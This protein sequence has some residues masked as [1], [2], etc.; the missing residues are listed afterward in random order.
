MNDLA[1]SHNLQDRVLLFLMENSRERNRSF[2]VI[3]EMGLTKHHFTGA[4]RKTY[5]ILL[6][7]QNE[8]KMSHL[9]DL[10]AIYPESE[11][12]NAL[13][14]FKGGDKIAEATVFPELVEKVI[15]TAKQRDLRD[16]SWFIKSELAEGVPVDSIQSKVQKKL[17]DQIISA[18]PGS[19]NTKD[20][21]KSVQEYTLKTR[22]NKTL[23]YKTGLPLVTEITS[24]IQ[25]GSYWVVGGQ[26]SIG[27]TQLCQQ[28]MLGAASDGAKVMM[29][30]LELSKN[31]MGVRFL[32]MKSDISLFD[33]KTKDLSKN[34]K[35]LEAKACLEKQTIILNDSCSNLS[36]IKQTIYSSKE[37]YGVDVFI[38]DYLQNIL[39][40]GKATEYEAINEI[41]LTLQ[42]LAIKENIAI[43]G[44]SQLNRDTKMNRDAGLHH[45]KGSGNIENSADIAITLHKNDDDKLQLYVN[46]NRL[47]GTTG[48]IDLFKSSSNSIFLEI[49]ADGEGFIPA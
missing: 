29:I 25:K 1:I 28:L 31:E 39:V 22:G 38:V 14:A 26:T 46:K 27:K 6:D 33:I 15:K 11:F 32:S 20:W 48:S 36:E 19:S 34:E 40:D 12:L 35:F 43:I 23:G 3:K 21:M 42:Q 24:G 7:R 41:S 47:L 2:E 16:L 9:E 8:G 10:I 37:K 4:R 49:P 30:S 5:E 45:F 18:K 13:I 44:V 17:Q